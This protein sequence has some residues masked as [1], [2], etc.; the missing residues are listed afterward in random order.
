MKTYSIIYRNQIVLVSR[1]QD[2][3]I[4]KLAPQYDPEPPVR[5]VFNFIHG[6][7]TTGRGS[8]L[9]YTGVYAGD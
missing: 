7:V 1:P 8:Q 9:C 3:F 5:P 6:P 4:T 2:F